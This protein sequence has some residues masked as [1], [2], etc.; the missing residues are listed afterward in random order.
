[1]KNKGKNI[2]IYLLF[3][4]A[5]VGFLLFTVSGKNSTGRADRDERKNNKNALV[6]TDDIKRKGW[7]FIWS[8]H[9]HIV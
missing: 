1:M 6:G 3:L 8:M 4:C 2:Y 5:F 9:K 7:M